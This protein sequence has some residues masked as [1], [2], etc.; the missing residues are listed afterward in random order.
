[1][2]VLGVRKPRP[3]SLYHRLVRVFLRGP[4]ALWFRKMCGYTWYQYCETSKCDA[5]GASGSTCFW[6]ARSDW[7]LFLN[8]HE[9]P[10]AASLRRT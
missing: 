1:M 10:T 8:Q 3:T 2:A 6:K 4:V 7:T 5:A 9:D